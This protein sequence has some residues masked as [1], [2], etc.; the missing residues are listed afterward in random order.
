MSTQKFNALVVDDDAIS[1]KTVGFN[2]EQEGFHCEYCTGAEDALKCLEKDRF[3]L[4]VTDLCMPKMHGHSLA[5]EVL[6]RP[7][8]PLVVA[9]SGIEDPRMTRELISRG[10]DD[11]IYK[12]TNYAG[13]AA[14]V[15]VWAAR[16]REA[17]ETTV[18][19]CLADTENGRPACRP[20]RTEAIDL[21][22]SATS[23]AAV[24]AAMAEKV[25]M[26]PTLSEAVLE[27]ANHPVRNN[28]GKRITDVKV[29]LG[30]VGMKKLADLALDQLRTNL[31]VVE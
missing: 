15:S 26:D 17:S 29:A 20:T 22:F 8:R 3:D 25:S 18:D 30:R 5:V 7:D 1:R 9:H 27:F 11:V 19:Q 24:F 31:V 23:D 6:S 13:F 28:T 16:R 2:L 21:F 10:V 14:K 12:P 4:V